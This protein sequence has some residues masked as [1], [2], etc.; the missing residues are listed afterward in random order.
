MS[1][2]CSVANNIPEEVWF[3]S[4]W[5]STLSRETW[6]SSVNQKAHPADVRQCSLARGRPAS[7]S[8][9]LEASFWLTLGDTNGRVSEVRAELVPLGFLDQKWM[10]TPVLTLTSGY[11]GQSKFGHVRELVGRTDGL[12]TSIT[13]LDSLY[14]P[15]VSLLPPKLSCTSTSPCSS[16]PHP[17][18]F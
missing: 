7:S 1:F 8:L 6:I 16:S 18:T 10:D 13:G 2:T 11:T 15:S 9:P 14:F 5:Q 17:S 3:P 12:S 4:A